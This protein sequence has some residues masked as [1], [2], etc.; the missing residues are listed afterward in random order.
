MKA[1]LCTKGLWTI[2]NDSEKCPDESKTE[3]RS[4]WDLRADRAAG[5]LYLALSSKQRTHVEAVQDDPVQIWSTLASIHLQQRPGARFNAW[6][7]FLS[8]R[9]QPDESLSSLIARI[10]D[11]MHHCNTMS[12]IQELHPKDTSSPYTIKD[13]DNELVCMAMVCSLG[14]EYSHFASSVLLFQSLHKE[15]LKEAFLAEELQ[16]KRRPE[17]PTS[18]TALFSSSSN[19]RCPTSTPC[20]FCEFLGHCVHKCQNLAKVKSVYLSQ[21]CKCNTPALSNTSPY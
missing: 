9:K 19:C 18:E 11:S 8:I 3:A 14:D 15:K 6:D 21:C 1:F 5:D 4:K 17:A 20:S 10:E 16:R 2:V 13:L 7:D 12:K